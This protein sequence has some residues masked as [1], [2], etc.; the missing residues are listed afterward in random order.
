MVIKT[1]TLEFK[2]LDVEDIEQA[3]SKWFGREIKIG[4][5]ETILTDYPE[6]FETNFCIYVEEED[7]TVDSFTLWPEFGTYSFRLEEEYIFN[8][9]TGLFKSFER[10]DNYDD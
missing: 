3:V 1:K 5:M 2:V 4:E 8:F 6:D 9:D 7:D 10:E